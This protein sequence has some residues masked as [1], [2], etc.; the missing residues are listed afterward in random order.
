[1]MN[2]R[3]FLASASAAAA[4][5][6][7]LAFGAPQPPAAEPLYLLT[8][9]HC[10]VILYG[11]ER[12]A[13][14]VRDAIAWLERH[15]AFKVGLDNEAWAYD[16]LAEHQPAILAEFQGYLKKYPGRFAIG[17]ATYGQPLSQFI[18]DESNIR[19]IAYAIAANRRHFGVTPPIYLMSEHAMHSQIPQLLAGFGFRGAIMRTH[20]M[21]YG[22]NPQF[23]LPIGQWVGADGSR[24]PTIPTY[25]NEGAKFG[26]ITDDNQILTRCP[27]PGQ[28]SPAQTLEKF[29]AKFSAIHPLLATRADD[30]NLRQE[31]LVKYTDTAPGQYKWILL[32]QI[33]Q[34]FPAPKKD[35][36]T[37][38]NDFK[39]RMPWGYCGNE[40]WDGCRRAEMAV[41]AA[42]R[43]AAAAFMLGAPEHHEAEL[44]TAWKNLL[45]TQHHDVQICGLLKDSRTYLP[46]SLAASAAVTKSALGTVAARMAG[47]APAQLTV[48]N[49]LSWDAPR[50]VEADV[51]LP[52]GW[53]KQA[54]HA[55]AGERP[56]PTAMLSSTKRPDGSIEQA[57]LAFLAEAPPLGFASYSLAPGAG[58]AAT[59]CRTQGLTILNGAWEIRLDPQGGI[60]ALNDIKTGRPLL[61]AG[62]RHG[63][64]AGVIDGKPLESQG[65]WT[66]QPPA[67]GAT[68]VTAREDGT[69]GAIPYHSTLTVHAESPRLDYRVTFKFDNQKIGRVSN[70]KKETFSPFLHEEKLRF[71]LFPAL[72]PAAATGLRD[73]PFVIAPTPDK[74]V[75]GNLWT[76]LA[77]GKQGVA[78]FNRGTMGSV[79]EADGGFSLPLAYAMYYVWGTRMLEGEFTYEF[80][81]YPFAG[82]WQ[83]AAVHRMAQEYAYA[84]PL[85]VTAPG[86]GELGREIRLF[87]L[88]APRRDVAFS[89]LYTENGKVLARLFAHGGG[90]TAATLK[91]LRRPAKLTELDLAGNALGEAAGSLDFT[92]WKFRTF[93]LDILLKNPAA[94]RRR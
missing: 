50:W 44:Q 88:A 19:Q 20:F 5:A 28:E 43:L 35:M 84:W 93:R 89:A 79:R 9:D 63:V 75:E 52:P 66:I 51:T 77:D 15:P 25:R 14:M 94:S 6:S 85:A 65:K 92:P 41:L 62:Q 23:D 8:Y 49:P 31:G 39:V 26:G 47:A 83:E 54:L 12:F 18:G 33:P 16:Y 57:R 68:W 34:L 17:T 80:A 78:F 30:A 42:E 45:V 91:C 46:L 71:K 73:L 10:G 56:V 55:R 72:E 67:P 53:T 1:M 48:F 7:T 32:E 90:Q 87:D 60:A 2:R 4:A 64:F 22:Y 27:G 69:I 81:V 58:P 11:H 82:D 24:V 29:R 61:A 21:M 37:A 70:N 38:P 13:S 36:P 40:I 74:Y 76:A 3:Q 86:S 59:A